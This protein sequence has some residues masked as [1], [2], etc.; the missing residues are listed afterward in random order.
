[1]SDAA[2]ARGFEEAEEAVTAAA[3]TPRGTLKLTCSVTF[4][5]RHLAPALAA[6]AARHPQMR[7]DVELSDRAWTSSTRASTSRYALATSA[8]RA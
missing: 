4:G 2:A 5:V 8:A 6:F 3:V 7:F 1:M